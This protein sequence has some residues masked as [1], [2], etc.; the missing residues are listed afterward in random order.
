MSLNLSRGIDTLNKFFCAN[1]LIIFIVS[2]LYS[3]YSLF[4]YYFEKG[5]YFAYFRIPKLDLTFGDLRSITYS[6]ECNK[7]LDQLRDPILNCDP[8]KRPFNYPRLILDIFRKLEINAN[9]TN[10]VGLLFGLIITFAIIFFIFTYVKSKDH[11]F[12]ISSIFLMS[13]PTQL[14]IERANY[15]S[16]ILVLMLFIPIF[17]DSYIIKKKLNLSIGIIISCLCICLK[18]YPAAGLIFWRF[19]NLFVN[20]KKLFYIREILLILIFS[21]TTFLTINFNN[22]NLILKNTPK[23][24]GITSFGLNN[25]YQLENNDIVSICFLLIKIFII[26]FI[27]FKSYE[28]LSRQNKNLKANFFESKILDLFILFSLQILLLYILFSSW[29]YRLILILGLIPF[30]SNYWILIPEKIFINKKFIPYIAIFIGYQQYLPGKLDALT[31]YFSDII[32]QPILI[33]FLISLL[34]FISK[35]RTKYSFY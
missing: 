30:F 1:S 5:L 22:L 13:S 29:D 25:L 19:Y 33:G 8:Y 7:T 24:S 15:D 9:H 35:K 18:I 21:L 28:K 6:S 11:K 26:L 34:L 12:L 10:E 32:I 23:P 31:S 3:L 27:F 17:L 20:D 14:V 4:A 16:L 2:N